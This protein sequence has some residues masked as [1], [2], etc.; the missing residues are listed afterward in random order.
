MILIPCSDAVYSG[1]SLKI[2]LVIYNETLISNPLNR[3]LYE[4]LGLIPAIIQ[5]FLL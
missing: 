3:L 5:T 2:F 4:F 1:I